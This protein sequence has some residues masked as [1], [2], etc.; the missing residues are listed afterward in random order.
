MWWFPWKKSHGL[1]SHVWADRHPNGSYIKR[2]GWC[3]LE[4]ECPLLINSNRSQHKHLQTWWVL[5]DSS[6][7]RFSAPN[8]WTLYNPTHCSKAGTPWRDIPG[9][10]YGFFGKILCRNNYQLK[11]NLWKTSLSGLNLKDT[12]L[13]CCIDEN[14]SVCLHDIPGTGAKLNYPLK[15]HN[16]FQ[17]QIIVCV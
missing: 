13:N 3:L 12:S 5:R 6:F 17:G 9:M 16:G 14:I 15:C 4:Y 8:L 10:K 1:Q 2:K 7:H 11:D